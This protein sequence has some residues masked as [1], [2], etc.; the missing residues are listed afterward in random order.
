MNEIIAQK[1]IPLGSPFQGIGPLGLQGKTAADAPAIFNQ[2]ISS[3]IGVM[4]IIAFVW[5]IF[6]LITG[7]IG[8]IN[9]GGD[10]AAL[11]TARKNITTGITGLI[12]V[13]AG[14]FIIDL[15]GT[16]LGIPN[17]L[18]PAELLKQVLIK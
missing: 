13:I 18:N 9:A 14:I 7:A 12:V 10:K 3:T 16:L 5:F 6:K 4:T 17:I 1:E 2:F 11:E 8:I 15:I